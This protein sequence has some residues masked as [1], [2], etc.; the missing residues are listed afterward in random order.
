MS[1]IAPEAPKLPPNEP[2]NAER[3]IAAAERKYGL[4]P[5]ILARTLWCE[6]SYRPDAI[7]D[8]G[9]SYGIAQIHL[10]AHPQVTPEEALDPEWAVEWAAQAFANGQARM[11]TCFRQ[12]QP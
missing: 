3:A 10:P 7:G 2:F 1:A 9:T 5:N 8:G 4:E 6:S 12:L 11:W